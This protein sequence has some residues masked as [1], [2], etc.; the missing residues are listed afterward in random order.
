MCLWITNLCA[1]LISV[2]HSVSAIL[3]SVQY[4]L[5]AASACHVLSIES[6]VSLSSVVL[7]CDVSLEILDQQLT[8]ATVSVV[9]ND[10]DVCD[11][12]VGQSLIHPHLGCCVAVFQFFTQTH[13][14]FDC[15]RAMRSW[16][17]FSASQVLLSCKSR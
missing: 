10:A 3:L 16:Q 1:R 12:V 2:T 11:S 14:L 6:P 4:T 15:L 9:T 8:A 7:Q 13:H 17:S 5:Q